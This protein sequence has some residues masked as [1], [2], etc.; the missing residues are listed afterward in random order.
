MGITRKEEN[1]R[2]KMIVGMIISIY[3]LLILYVRTTVYFTNHFYFGSE[4]NCINVSGKTV[5]EVK[6]EMSSKLQAYTLNLKERGGTNEQIRAFDIGLRYNSGGQYKDFKDRQNPY[7]WVWALFNTESFKMTDGVSYDEKLLKERVD[8]L[9]CFN[10]NNIIEPQNP[11]FQY[12]D[13]GYMIVS[14]VNGN[15]VNKDILYDQVA[16]AILKEKTAIDLELMDCYVHPEYT[17]NSPKIIE[18]RNTLNKYAASKITYDFGERKETIDGSI[19]N[20]WLGVNGNL[21]II[22]DEEK[23]KN[24]LDE[25]L[26]P[27]STVGKMR[28]FVT[29]SGRTINIDGGDYGWTIDTAKE[30]QDLSAAVKEGQTVTKEPAYTQRAASHDNSDIGDTYVEV[31]MTNQHLWFYKN[32]SLI[33]QGDVVTGNMRG[34]HATPEGVYRL[35]YKQTHTILK[36]QD[37][38]VPVDFW[39]PFNGGIGIHDASWRSVF[40]GNI[41]KTNGSHGC[42]NSPYYLAK[43]IFYNIAPGDPVICYY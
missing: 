22:V 25:I 33:V 34:N 40:G 28:S 13:K 32:G 14:E 23:V 9:A 8:Q 31:D 27:Y 37:Y 11:G 38:S 19:I 16:K 10:S 43:T 39:M 3:I 1:K 36:G 42:I 35:K 6:E 7:K 29:S 26:S 12:T 41:Y 2:N 15:K 4:I 5:E 21:D 18:T 17:S 20:K 30:A 24:D